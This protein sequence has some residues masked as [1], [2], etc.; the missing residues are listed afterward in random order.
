MFTRST[1]YYDALYDMKDYAAA[2][3]RVEELIAAHAPGACRLLDVGCGTGRHLEHLRERYDVEGLDL[4]PGMV[5]RA[6]ERLPGVPVHV[7]DMTDFR[8]PRAFDVVTCLFSAIAYVGTAPA[9]A[10]A[11]A[12][13]AEHLRPGGL[14]LLEPWFTPE[15][16][17]ADTITANHVDRPDL[18]IAW[19]YTSR[20]EDL[21]SVLDIHYM[22]GT[23][24]GVERFEER[25]ELGL[26]THEEH[27]GALRA[28]G[29]EA[30]HDPEGLFDRGLYLGVRR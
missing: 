1:A 9:M 7:A 3:A 27:L 2:S 10:R 29:L 18:K 13:M 14:L 23:P 28:A 6:R 19:M 8:L 4:D 24:A 21:L 20:R 26:F 30:R 11:V 25:H 17:W 15:A 12:R 22:V 5:A 16:F